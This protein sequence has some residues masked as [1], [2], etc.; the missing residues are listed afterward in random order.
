MGSR[1]IINRNWK[2][3]DLKNPFLNEG[4]I[5]EIELI[6]FSVL[7]KEDGFVDRSVHEAA[8][9]MISGG[10]RDWETKAVS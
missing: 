10:Y 6:R 2:L 5:K 1:S 3:M 4:A 7:A 8:K 9:Q